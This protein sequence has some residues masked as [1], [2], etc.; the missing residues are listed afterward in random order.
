MDKLGHTILKS[1][2]SYGRWVIHT[3]P[4]TTEYFWKKADALR[5][6]AKKT[7]CLRCKGTGAVDAP[8]SADD[9]TCEKCDGTGEITP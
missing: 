5:W 6:L 7:D 2:S 8:T 1:N 4:A 9:P 3:G